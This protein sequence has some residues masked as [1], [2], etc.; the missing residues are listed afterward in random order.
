[1]QN[2]YMDAVPVDRIKEYQLKLQE[3]F[4][5]RKDSILKDIAAKK[6][7]DGDLEKTLKGALE[8]FKTLFR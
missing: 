3:F 4:T 5:T 6:Q 1:M 2:G 8:E 7:I